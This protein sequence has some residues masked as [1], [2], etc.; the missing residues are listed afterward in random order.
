MAF[1]KF[2][3]DAKP[4]CSTLNATQNLMNSPNEDVTFIEQLPLAKPQHKLK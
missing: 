1:F 3:E 2:P 4:G